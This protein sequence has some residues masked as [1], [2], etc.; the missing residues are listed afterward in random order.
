MLRD[1]V[2]ASIILLCLDAMFISANYNAYADQIVNVQRTA[3]TINP[4][5]A[6]L[7]YFFIIAG[8]YFFI[9]RRR[10]PLDEA[11]VFGI[12]VYGV[13]DATNYA[14]V[15][16]WSPTLATMDTIWGGTLMAITTFL[17]YSFLDI[18]IPQATL[19]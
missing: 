9:L 12:I 8:L 2:I 17:T 16:K 18:Q 11:F 10:R 19:L 4:V 14:M 1:I 3:M 15:K 5:G 13:Y 6:L 7:S